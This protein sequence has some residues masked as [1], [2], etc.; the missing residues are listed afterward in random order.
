MNLE[1]LYQELII[2]HGTQPRNCRRLENANHEAEGFNP[3]CGDK[4]QI[5]LKVQDEQ[6]Q[7]AS[8]VGHGCAICMA[9][10]S[11]MTEALKGQSLPKACALCVDFKASV[12]Q[13]AGQ[14]QE[15]CPKLAEQLG[16]LQ[17][18]L[19]VR[20][21]PSR[22]KCATLPWHALEAAIPS[23]PSTGPAGHLLPLPTEKDFLD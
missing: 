20:A 13:A 10:A 6:I 8:F 4:V 3:L 11:L 14:S 23:F 22:V 12:C 2:D 19:G 15:A 1:D 5:F 16:K 21:F 9:S 18:L 7:D 17:A